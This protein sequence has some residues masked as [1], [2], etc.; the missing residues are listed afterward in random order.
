M[1]L[2]KHYRHPVRADLSFACPTFILQKSNL[3]P[4]ISH[5]LSIPLHPLGFP[6]QS[7]R[8]RDGDLIRIPNVKWWQRRDYMLKEEEAEMPGEEEDVS[9]GCQEAVW[10][11]GR[12]SMRF[13]SF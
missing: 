1:W 12:N 10:L 9:T 5:P 8:G 3:F 7:V 11:N 2:V 4:Y 13:L 6:W